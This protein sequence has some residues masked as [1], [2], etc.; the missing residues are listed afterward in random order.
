M[1]GQN[2]S[3]YLRETRLWG[4]DVMQLL[5]EL[6]QWGDTLSASVIF[7]VIWTSNDD[8]EYVKSLPFEI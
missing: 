4:K 6:V 2:I 5:V 3:I 7:L 8:C 1:I